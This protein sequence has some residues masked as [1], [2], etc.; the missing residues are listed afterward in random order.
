M[1]ALTA[2]AS[3]DEGDEVFDDAG[4]NPETE[5]EWPDGLA[6]L[7]ELSSDDCPRLTKSGLHSFT[8]NGLE[9]E[10]LIQMPRNPDPGL[11][12]V[13]FWHG[14]GDSA[15]G[16]DRALGLE[17]FA[18]DNDLI[19]VIP[20][21]TDPFLL[22]WNVLTGGDDAALFDDMR[23]CL[24][25][26]L[27]VDLEAVHTQGFSYG[28]MMSTWLLLERSDTLA[29][30][31]ILSGGTDEG[32][33]LGYKRP[34]SRVPVAITWGG[35]ADVFDAGFISIDFQAAAQDLIDGLTGDDHTIAA[36]NHGLGHTLPY[37]YEDATT[38]W[39][40]EN[41]FGQPSPFE[42]GIGGFPDYCELITSR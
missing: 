30:A 13:F 6:P 36:C 34:V 21:S 32:L 10:V 12:V 23:T 28:A 16:Y 18:K 25:R 29:S 3:E 5:V 20:Q 17:A 8:S 39:L 41:R 31:V 2:C 42:D 35:T 26:E 24:S 40:L 14:L 22:T 7:A 37:D 11:P 1:L 9:R 4:T 15:E 19:A 27:D 38:P 33:G